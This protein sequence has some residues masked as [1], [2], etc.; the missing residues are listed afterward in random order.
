MLKNRPGL[1]N[2]AVRNIIIM[3]AVLVMLVIISVVKL[4]A[5]GLNRVT[6]DR[7]VST[8]QQIE[9]LK[10][11]DLAIVEP[12]TLSDIQLKKL[13]AADV[14]VV[15]YVPT[16]SIDQQW[17]PFTGLRESDYLLINRQKVANTNDN[18]PD[19]I[20]DP[21]S[22]HYRQIITDYA[23][24]IYARGFDGVFLDTLAEATDYSNNREVLDATVQLVREIRNNDP[25]K[26]IVQNGGWWKNA[27]L[28]LIDYTAPLIDFL[29]WEHYPY[30]KT[31]GDPW[32]NAK[33][34]HIVD[35][36]ERYN[37]TV[38]TARFISWNDYAAVQTYYDGARAYGFV[39]YAP[40]TSGAPI[41]NTVNTYY[42]PPRNN[43]QIPPLPTSLSATVRRPADNIKSFVIHWGIGHYN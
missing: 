43:A 2:T 14:L 25:A 34:N 9:Y 21:R 29:M 17:T 32:I 40:W 26:L 41:Y 33:R 4:T 23:K 24:G 31:T 38:L 35:L 7:S 5:F 13:Q 8:A 37:F 10:R 15:A 30:E 12:Y 18:P 19:W 36:S 28:N 6:G 16:T 1:K 22:T 27:P 39:P 3:L 42:L 20:M 11:F